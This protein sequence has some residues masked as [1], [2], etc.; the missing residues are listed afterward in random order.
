MSENN[1]LHEELIEELTKNVI[2]KKK[3]T[4]TKKEGSTIETPYKFSDTRRL[5]NE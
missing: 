5:S 2:V 4:D 1:I 3:Y